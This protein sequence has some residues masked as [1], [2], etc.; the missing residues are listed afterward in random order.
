MIS[1]PPKRSWTQMIAWVDPRW[2]QVGTWAF[3]LNR[4]TAIGITVY[5]FMHLVVLGQ[6]A[7]GPEAYDSF[8]ALAKT[9]LFL[10]GELLVI[11][12]A[13]YHGLNGL[14]IALTS[15]GIGVRYQKEMFYGIL[16]IVAAAGLT[17]AV[18]MFG[19]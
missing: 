7:Q 1:H 8:V 6:L 16:A 14:R 10:M 15:F 9:P 18:V 11:V 3:I 2:R 17:F 4:L 12:A 5:L 13:L 19:H